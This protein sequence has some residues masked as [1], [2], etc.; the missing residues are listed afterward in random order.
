MIYNLT[1]INN[2]FLD[3]LLVFKR[4]YEKKIIQKHQLMKIINEFYSFIIVV[5]LSARIF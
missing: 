4:I 2:Y 1:F 3:I 5:F